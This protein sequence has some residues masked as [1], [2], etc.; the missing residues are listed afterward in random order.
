MHKH[1]FSRFEQFFPFDIK[2]LGLS[3]GVVASCIILILLL[4]MSVFPGVFATH[5]PNAVDL[6]NR[7]VQPGVD[8]YFGTDHHGR[9][10]YSRVVYGA[11]TSMAT[12]LSVVA[13]GVIVGTLLGLIAGYYGGIIDQVMMRIVDLF[14]AFP[15][16][17]LAIALVGL[18]GPSLSNIVLALSVMWWVSYA[19]IIRGVVLQVKEKDFIKGAYLMGGEN[20]YI[21][22]KHIIPHVLSPIFALATL[23]VGS[24]ILHITGLSFLGLGAQPPTAEWGSMIQGSIAFM[25]TAP[26]TMIF[27]G[28]CIVI[29]VISFNYLGD[30]IKERSDPVRMEKITV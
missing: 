26:Q 28:L 27:P 6:D 17:I 10:I 1:A 19:R 23:D 18:F 13:I 20:R 3:T 22:R 21:I 14:L 9:D 29:T 12:A 25:E 15:A 2:S 11:R 4:C 30:W 7:L 24:A 8:H 16:T 5:D